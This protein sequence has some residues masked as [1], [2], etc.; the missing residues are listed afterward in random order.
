LKSINNEIV[1]IMKNRILSFLIVPALLLVGMMSGCYYDEVIYDPSSYEE[2]PN[3][4]DLV[5]FN[6]DI[7]PIFNSGCNVSGCH[8]TG[9]AA[10]DLTDN[11]AYNALIN[12]GY[13]DLVSPKQSE[14]YRWVNGEGSVTMPISGTDPQI[15]SDILSWIQQGA[16]NN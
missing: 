14:L 4:G 12:G 5:T 6:A 11:N 8:S 9:G 7:L 13:I 3:G 10:P 15:V 1:K 2:D 16:Q